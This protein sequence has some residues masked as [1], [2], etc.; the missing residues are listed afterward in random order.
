M[1][2]VTDPADFAA[3]FDWFIPASGR[4]ISE[5]A[6][7]NVANGLVDEDG[8]GPAQFLAFVRAELAAGV[9]VDQLLAHGA[10][11]RLVDR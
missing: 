11:T 7:L 4:W 6:E 1:P 9:P 8:F 5:L 2:D 10:V 3:R